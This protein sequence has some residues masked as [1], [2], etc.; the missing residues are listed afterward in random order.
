MPRLPAALLLA[1]LPL[2]ALGCARSDGIVRVVDGRAVHGAYVPAEAYASYLRGAIADAS[3]D[4]AGAVEGYSI[5]VAL[6][7]SDPEVWA[8][9][10]AAECA[11]QPRD[12]KADEAFARAFAIDGDYGPAWAAQAD[13]A[14][15]RGDAHTAAESARRAVEQESDRRATAGALR[16]R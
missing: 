13:C 7:P 2:G 4:V 16:E 14:A 5:A 6:G 11:R 1:V 10:G 3:G 12:P 8:R 9:L 15:R